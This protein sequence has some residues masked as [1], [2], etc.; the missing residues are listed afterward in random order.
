MG[1][2]MRRPKARES[3]PLR[4]RTV[5]SPVIESVV[6]FGTVSAASFVPDRARFAASGVGI[7]PGRYPKAE[8][9]A[10]P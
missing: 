4:V 8:E 9:V 5:V 7:R 10:E 3:T 2:G 6:V 1:L